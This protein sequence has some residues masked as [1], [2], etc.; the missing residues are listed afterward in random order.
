M[1]VPLL[2]RV[3]VEVHARCRFRVTCSQHDPQTL[4][5]YLR[6]TQYRLETLSLSNVVE[7]FIVK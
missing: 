6:M 5:L 4:V 7:H 3:K 1:V 2:Y